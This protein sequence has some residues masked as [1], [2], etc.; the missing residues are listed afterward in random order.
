VKILV[1]VEEQ[2]SPVPFCLEELGVLVDVSRLPLGDYL[3]AAGAAVERKTVRDLH[4]GLVNGRLWSQLFALR[5]DTPRPYLLVEGE[6]LDAGRVTERGVRGAL[7]Q[8]A[9]SGVFVVRSRDHADS[10]LWLFLIAKREQAQ[11]GGV[12]RRRRGR[13]RIV[14]SP[15]GVLATVPGISPVTANRLLSHFG[16]IARIAAASE[17]DLQEVRGIGPVHAAE[18]SR[19]L[20]R[21]HR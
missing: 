10:A 15:A 21:T 17:C 4:A 14:V 13:R 18:L 7:L 19:V 1:D 5:R 12:T 16:S 20:N 8:I 3:V 2:R 9:G 6:N 11:A